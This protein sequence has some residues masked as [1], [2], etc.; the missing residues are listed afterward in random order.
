MRIFKILYRLWNA[1]RNG[2]YLNESKSEGVGLGRDVDRLSLQVPNLGAITEYPP[3][4]FTDVGVLWRMR[5][6]TI[7]AFL[8]NDMYMKCPGIL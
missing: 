8:F 6:R 3:T 2:G 7:V 1:V 5:Y 4:S